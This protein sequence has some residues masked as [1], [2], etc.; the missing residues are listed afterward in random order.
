MVNGNERGKTVTR[1]PTLAPPTNF[2]T[3]HHWNSSVRNEVFQ[4][5]QSQRALCTTDKS[6]PSNCSIWSNQEISHSAN[7]WSINNWLINQSINWSV[8]WVI[9][10]LMDWFGLVW[11][12]YFSGGKATVRDTADTTK[13]SLTFLDSQNIPRY[14]QFY[15]LKVLSKFLTRF[16]IL[17]PFWRHV[18]HALFSP[19][20]VEWQHPSVVYCVISFRVRGC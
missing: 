18:I 15:T 5:L 16:Y 19:V 1:K 2:T 17:V 6:Q 4:G 14:W 20:Q 8:P 9:G 13:G 11:I 10:Q 3:E 12:G 7:Y